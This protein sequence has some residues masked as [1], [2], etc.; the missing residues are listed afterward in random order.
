M[1]CCEAENSFPTWADR[2]LLADGFN[3]SLGSTTN[4]N[5]LRLGFLRYD[6]EQIDA[7]QTIGKLC[8]LHFNVVDQAERQT[9]RALSDTLMQVGDALVVFALAAGDGQHAFLHLDLQVI[10]HQASSRDHDPIMIVTVLFDVV[11]WVGGTGLA[12]K[13]RFEK[14]VEPVKADGVT[15][16]WGQ[17][18]SS[19]HCKIS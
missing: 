4:R 10:L 7:Q 8:A 9:E 13:R 17:G 11:R 18:K 3:I 1:Y 2:S 15:E 16:Q 6:P 12:A 5:A 19:S 14:V